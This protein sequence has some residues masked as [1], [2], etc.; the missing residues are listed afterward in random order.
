MPD[1]AKL[2]GAMGLAILAFVV[3]GMVMRLFEEDTNFG[4]FVHVNVLLGLAVG[5]VFIGRRA[6][7]GWTSA[8]NVGLTG[9][10]VLVFWGLFIQ[11][12]NEMTR[13]AMKNRYDGAGEALT[14]VFEIGAEWVILMSTI[15]IWGTV[16]IGG[17][18]TG[19]AT[20]IAW[21]RW[22]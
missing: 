20:E 7:R 4:W 21:R 18:L 12:C 14:A 22:R 13:L 6:G 10:V 8:V 17:V 16:A 5:W 19:I 9:G 3:S 15:Q 1:A 2:V 11:S